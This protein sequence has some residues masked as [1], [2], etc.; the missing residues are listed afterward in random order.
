MYAKELHT[1][2][3]ARPTG[4]MRLFLAAILA[5]IAGCIFLIVQTWTWRTRWTHEVNTT[6]LLGTLG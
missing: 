1:G 2:L 4:R 3:L 6:V 5:T